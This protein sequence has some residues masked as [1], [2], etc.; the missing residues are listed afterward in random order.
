MDDCGSPLKK[1]YNK[2]TGKKN[3]IERQMHARDSGDALCAA[4]VPKKSKVDFEMLP[5]ILA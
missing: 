2:L 5:L 3:F 1:F 4:K